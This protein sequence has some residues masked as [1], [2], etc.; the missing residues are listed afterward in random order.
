MVGWP[1]LADPFFVVTGA[2]LS[3]GTLAIS[4]VSY[5][6]QNPSAC[7]RAKAIY[8]TVAGIL[9]C[10]VPLHPWALS[11]GYAIIPSGLSLFYFM[12]GLGLVGVKGNPTPAYNESKG[13]FLELM[14]PLGLM[15]ALPMLVGK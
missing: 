13:L 5:D 9:L 11:F 14:W 7:P 12:L 10:G 3:I 8:G 6:K 2:V 4:W 15:L 1:T